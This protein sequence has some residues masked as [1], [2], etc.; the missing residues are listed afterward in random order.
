[1]RPRLSS[2]A[3][4]TVVYGLGEVLTRMFSLLLLPLITSYLTP[5]EYGAV[6]LLTTLNL[7]IVP[8]CS[9]GFGAG[10]APVYFDGDDL[11]HKNATIATATAVMIGM[12]ILVGVLAFMLRDIL[13]NWLLGSRQ[14]SGLVT[15]TV[16]AS[17]FTIATIPWR[18]RLQFDR[19]PR[20]YIV[21]SASILA[22]TTVATAVLL[23]WFKKGASGVIEAS[24]AGQAFGFV[25]FGVAGGR[26][27]KGIRIVIARELMAVGLPLVPAFGFMFVL[28][29][30][31]KYALQWMAGLEA[32]GKFT[33][34]ANIG[35]AVSV[36]VTSF[37]NAWL[38]YFM[39]FAN[40][41][42]EGRVAIGKA[43]TYYC[44][45][46][47]SVSL[48]LFALAR[49]LVALLAKPAYYES[50]EVVGLVGAAQFLGGV[51]LVL[52][53]GLYYAKE[54][55][56]VGLIQGVAAAGEIAL[57]LLLV[58]RLGIVGAA[59]AMLLGYLLLIGVQ[60]RWNVYRRYVRI[61]YET[62]RVARFALIYVAF[63]LLTVIGSDLSRSAE[64]VRTGL[65]L[66][67]LPVVTYWQLTAE[68]RLRLQSVFS[69]V[70][71]RA[72]IASAG[73]H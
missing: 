55:R 48:A 3:Q 52:L 30:G 1:M 71:G 46:L 36:A 29:H 54:V 21:L 45:A 14:F 42:N 64:L 28:Q 8:V 2:L 39:L 6:S 10:M 7:F 19:R 41:L 22:V 9:L 20:R 40:R 37:Q 57:S 73:T 50:W 63:A 61:D 4:D 67:G 70:L 65:L 47:G 32:V 53:P 25:A 11:A 51:F 43:L 33:V 16:L 60:Y 12:G 66:A 56:Y 26:L 72:P 62:S 44:L 24:L 13:S 27:H 58:P 38:P 5:A 31:T 17:S 49:P 23:I 68:E 15:L 35:L 18:Q 59:L 34:G 69:T